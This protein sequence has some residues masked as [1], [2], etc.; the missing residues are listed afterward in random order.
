MLRALATARVPLACI[1][2]CFASR[3]AHAQ[4]RVSILPIPAVRP[5]LLPVAPDEAGRQ[6]IARIAGGALLGTIA[7]VAVGGFVGGSLDS[8]SCE[9]PD[10]CLDRALLG[11]FWGGTGGAAVGAPLGAHFGNRSQ[12]RLGAS[13][14]ASA[15]VFGAEIVA[16]RSLLHDGQTAHKSTVFAIMTLTPVLQAITSTIV[17]ARTS[18]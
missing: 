2:T 14:L 17:E 18:P 12:G 4:Q 9:N 15:A 6:S 7:G 13:L 10:T 16:L 8:G 11:F 3:G 1:L 5:V